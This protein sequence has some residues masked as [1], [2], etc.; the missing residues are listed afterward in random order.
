MRK[1]VNK[2]NTKDTRLGIM[3]IALSLILVGSSTFALFTYMLKGTSTLSFGKI[4]IS[5][6]NTNIAF[7]KNLS[8]LMPGVNLLANG[9]KIHYSVDSESKSLYSRVLF[10]FTCDSSSPSI[11]KEYVNILNDMGVSDWG[12]TSNI[13]NTKWIKGENYFY[14]LVVD[15]PGNSTNNNVVVLNPGQDITFATSLEIP[16]SLTQST[17][18]SGNP[19]QYGKSISLT[20]TIQALQYEH[21]VADDGTSDPNIDN[22]TY[23]MNEIFSPELNVIVE[24]PNLSVSTNNLN[25]GTLSKYT[26]TDTDLVLPSTFNFKNLK[27]S[28]QISQSNF[29]DY[30]E[31]GESSSGEQLISKFNFT[32]YLN[33]TDYDAKQNGLS[34]V[35]GD[36]ANFDGSTFTPSDSNFSRFLSVFVSGMSDGNLPYAVGEKGMVIKGFK[37]T[38]KSIGDEAFKDNT[39]IKTITLPSTITSIGDSAFYG[40]TSLTDINIPSGL[41]NVGDQAFNN[42][43]TLNYYTTG[44]TNNKMYYLGNS[45][46]NYIILNKVDTTISQNSVSINPRTKII[47]DSCFS[48][49]KNITS[50]VIPSEITEIKK[51]TFNG[52]VNLISISLPNSVK[53]IGN[54]AFYNCSKLESLALPSSLVSIG[55]S[56]FYSCKQLTTISLPD[57]IESIG[58]NVFSSCTNLNNINIPSSIKNIGIDV[59]KDCTN[60]NYYTT[61]DTN[62]KLYYLGNGS[63]NRLVLVKVDSTIAGEVS[64]ID[65]NTKFIMN[66]V[67][68]DCTSLT[69]ILIPNSIKEIKKDTF[70][71]CSK[72]AN[73]IIP[74]SI[75]ALNNSS[76][77]GCTS[78]SSISIPNSVKV[79]NEFAFGC[80]NLKNIEILNNNVKIDNFAFFEC[81][82]NSVR[83]TTSGTGYSFV[84][85]TLNLNGSGELS[86]LQSYYTWYPF[87]ELIIT[88]NVGDSYTG[89]EGSTFSGSTS[90]TSIVLPKSLISIGDYAFGGCSSLNNVELPSG[91]TVLS[92]S[93]F[94]GCSSLSSLTING[95]ITSVGDKTFENCSNLSKISLSSSLASIG[96]SAFVGCSSLNNVVLPTGVTALSDSLFS[97]CSSLSNLTING[98]ITSI[99]AS[100]FKDCT[101]LSSI[102]L[103]KSNSLSLSSVGANAFSGCKF[104]EVNYQSSGADYSFNNG[105]LSLTGSGA[106]TSSWTNWKEL[107]LSVN[108]G[109]NYTSIASYSFSGCNDLSSLTLPSTLSL[110]SIGTSAFSGCKFNNVLYQS[111][112]GTDYSFINGT[113][114]LSGSGALTSSWGNWKELIL[115]VNSSSTTYTSVGYEAFSGCASLKNIVIPNGIINISSYAFSGCKSLTGITM[116]SSLKTI[117]SYAFRDCTNL[118]TITIDDTVENPNKLTSIDST[119]FSNCDKLF[120]KVEVGT[121]GKYLYYINDNTN[122]HTILVKAD[123]DISGGVT[124][125]SNTKFIVN[126]AFSDCSSLKNAVLPTSITILSD[127][128]FSDCSSLSNLT[129]NGN[130]TYIGK[131]VFK[132]CMS[133]SSLTLPST[134]TLS[135]IDTSAFSGCKFTTINYQ[136]VGGT[137]Y[138]FI[139]GTLSLSGSGAITSSWENWKELILS[140]NIGTGYTSIGSS[141]FSNCINLTSINI[142]SNVSSIG[143]SAFSCCTSLSSIVLPTSITALGSSIFSGCASLSSIVL[144]KSLTSIGSYAFYNCTNLSTVTID[145][146]A[147][148]PNKLTSIDSTAFSNC[149]K[150]FVKVEIGTTGKYLYYINDNTN[151]HIILVKV[152]KDV[153]SE[154]SIDN[155]V[156]F[157][158]NDAFNGCV[159]LRSITLSSTLPLSSIGSNAF[160]GCKFTSIN[161]QSAGGTGYSFI[162]G[163]LSLSDSGTITFSWGNWKELILSVN[164]GTGYTSIGASAFSNCINLTSINIPSNVSSIGNSAFSCCTSL[165]SIVLP[166]SITALG[167]SIFSGCASLSSIVLPKSLTSIGSYAFY[168]CTNLSNITLPT[169]LTSI[170]SSAFSS[171][172][173]LNNVVLPNGI[174]ILRD[175]LFSNC[176]N[177]S[178]L[179]I[180]GNITSIGSN[181]FSGCTSLSN[182]T[183]P[184][185][186]TSIGES[187]F[188]GCTSLNN[189]V[190][191]NGIT[192]LN[193]SLFSNCSNLST[194]TINGSVTS[195]GKYTFQNCKGLSSITLPNSL[196]SIDWDAF[197]N[198][199]NLRSITLP[200]T[201]PLSSIGSNA[202]GGCKFTSINY[203]STGGTGYSFIDGTLSL[204]G[205]GTITFSWGNWKELILSVNIGTGYTSIGASAFSNCV[206]LTSIEIPSNISSIGN[207]AFSGCTNLTSLT[208]PSTF[209]S[210][211]IGTSAFSGCKFTSINYQS[212]GTDYSFNN[213]VL[214]LTGSGAVT[215]SWTNWGE[216]ILS[217]NIGMDYN[218]IGANAFSGC[219]NLSS[220]TIPSAIKILGEKAFYGCTN[221][222]SLIVGE[223]LTTIGSSA[224]ENCI[225]LASITIPKTL[226]GYGDSCFKGCNSLATVIFDST[227][228]AEKIK[229]INGPTWTTGWWIFTTTH[230]T[231][232]VS[233]ATTIKVKVGVSFENYNLNKSDYV[234][235]YL[236]SSAFI[237]PNALENGYLVF[238]K[239]S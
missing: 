76:F 146:T 51:D 180:S 153:S 59:F 52:C 177:L 190:L 179:T 239:V 29:T 13:A 36:S 44:D 15:L 40:C 161:Y 226:N 45:L 199:I 215:S 8:G 11:I 19:I 56:A 62:N 65:T 138:S 214:S 60:L 201:L 104:N 189:V 73:V 2:S 97:G 131:N 205:S 28:E 71:G 230:Q 10:E 171:C 14:Y 210:S 134:L 170:G 129:I 169:T 80:T 184:T 54:S 174:T 37:Y 191:P 100:T 185:T 39:Q 7:S 145:D 72:L 197:S 213:G 225:K 115:S 109:A 223:G 224:F 196:N 16:R 157:V 4:Q 125:D 121:T 23:S 162:D 102:N 186:L 236:L 165:S 208:L 175:N 181:T 154:V 26:G 9:E 75:T 31:E 66:G 164:I 222:T 61:G 95:N 17:D 98:S 168:N 149:D 105:I 55:N 92:N 137:D 195:I 89:I 38:L 140:V 135:S 122:Q 30:I 6:T 63:N 116:P 5:S 93:L 82:F 86:N 124:I 182:I 114:L 188:S 237:Q 234:G 57:I 233:N 136:S 211:S 193:D 187:A 151:K 35:K 18:E 160:S 32:A 209:S 159:N 144:P 217:V 58:D 112:G 25:E 113:L 20:I 42:C 194:L 107:I 34:I 83:F 229:D 218:S 87:K 172:T 142:P 49:C 123:K 219:T 156:K 183:L 41:T 202:F 232:I 204:S 46:N 130:I 108:I 74:D 206:N 216:L 88:A 94:S 84:D 33:K 141:A 166:T 101:S 64:S 47:M 103:S 176:S 43:Q 111:S 128:L 24:Y 110:S 200:S 96:A 167:S 238:T 231:Y 106:V 163:T 50:I 53:S 133:L 155:N 227:Y 79:I 207:S 198:C 99:G 91:I 192:K 22:I 118:T 70:S 90:L 147:E 12:L 203:Q 235:D 69:G 85:G 126:S 3:L 158:M 127:S 152:D 1:L 48:S 119:A 120:V 148:N 143:N 132:N 173:S 81:K 117:S 77:S 67:F 27:V 221:L 68:K 21:Y 150:L 220:I 228:M 178:T 78:L 139:N 212:T